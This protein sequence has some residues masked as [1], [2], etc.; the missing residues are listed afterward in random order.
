MLVTQ[1]KQ[2]KNGSIS[3]IHGLITIKVEHLSK[4]LV[5]KNTHLTSFQLI[6]REIFVDHVYMPDT[7]FIIRPG[8]TVIDIGAN[9]GMFTVYAASIHPNIRVYALEPA[10][11][12]FAALSENIRLNGLSNVSIHCCAVAEYN[13]KEAILYRDIK[14]GCHSL[15]R[16]T[17]TRALGLTRVVGTENIET[18]TLDSI[19]EQLKIDRCDFLKVDCEGGEHELFSACTSGTLNRIRRIAL[20]YHD[21]EERQTQLGLKLLLEHNGF[22]VDPLRPDMSKKE[23]V[24]MLYAVRK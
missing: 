21:L 4:E 6:Q 5:F 1:Q 16:E 24:G 8:E 14:G 10:W 15:L 20:E 11:D 13:S 2:A 23:N 7:R 3:D 22:C 17:P 9:I 19:F 18:C 12:N